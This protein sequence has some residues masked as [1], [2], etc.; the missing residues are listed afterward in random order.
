[1]R[2]ARKLFLLAAMTLTAMA[3][4]VSAASAQI[5]VQNES[6]TTECGL[7]LIV[8]NHAVNSRCH[9]EFVSPPGTDIPLHAYIPAKTTISSCELYLEG[10]IEEGGEGYATQAQLDAPHGG[11][12]PCTR[13]ACD[14]A[15]GTMIPWPF[16]IGEHGPSAEDLEMTLCL[17][18]SSTAPGT[19][20]IECEVHLA[21][22]DLGDHQYELGHATEV[23]CENNPPNGTLHPTLQFPVS[24]EPHLVSGQ[25]GIEVVH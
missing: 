23:F 19:L 1:M 10:Q 15:N 21:F 14:E 5:E 6:G 11:A 3:M 18:D 2:L 7:W 17:R 13:A 20:G 12:T 8:I 16:H 9:V 25:E 4:S 24:I 22:T